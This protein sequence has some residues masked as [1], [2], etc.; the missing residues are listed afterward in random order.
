MAK[1]WD[2]VERSVIVQSLLPLAF[3]AAVIYLSV[4]GRP[5]PEL[6]AHLTWAC[7]SFWMG[8]KIQHAVDANRAKRG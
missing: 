6:L 4:A 3:G 1:F 8:T 5:V 7:V 2:L